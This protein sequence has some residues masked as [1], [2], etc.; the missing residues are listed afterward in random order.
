MNY[1]PKISIVTP[2]FNQV[3]YIEQ[4]I[5]SVLNQN[6]PNLEYIIIDGGSSDGTIE[7]LKKYRNHLTYWISEEDEGMYHAINK[8]FLK[9]TGE[10]L[11][12]I[13]SDD[14]YF[15]N[16]FNVV[17]T[18]FNKMNKVDWLTGRCSYIDEAG[19][20]LNTSYKKL[21]NKELIR[22]GFY[23]SP[24]SYVINQN[25]VF[26]RRSLWERV[27]GCDKNFKAAG[28]F[29]LWKNF[30]RHSELYFYDFSFSA[31]RK[32]KDQITSSSNLYSKEVE[33]GS[34]SVYTKIMQIFFRKKFKAFEIIKNRKSK[35]SIISV[36]L[37]PKY[38][39]PR[40]IIT[41]YIKYLIKKLFLKGY[42]TCN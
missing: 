8:G 27:G 39:N 10:I 37:N 6:Y 28:D 9:S 16:A 22:C 29:V 13:N 3:N 20:I 1:V 24:F 12:W 30:A 35:L 40:K 2:S 19:N 23:R 36:N 34:S 15:E 17:A 25:V 26:W 7:I 41:N 31:F 14:I 42:N 11:A 4:T 18:I 38:L 33:L 5:Q 32:H 21:Y